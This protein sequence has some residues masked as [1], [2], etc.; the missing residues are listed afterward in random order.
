VRF[1]RGF[2]NEGS[3]SSDEV[4]R[5]KAAPLDHDVGGAVA[6]RRLEVV[7]DVAARGE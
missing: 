6:P 7:A 3:V 5:R 1:T 4:Q 2:G